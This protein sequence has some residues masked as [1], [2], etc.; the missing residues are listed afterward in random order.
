MLSLSRAQL[1]SLSI[2]VFAGISAYSLRV[3]ADSPKEKENMIVSKGKKVSIEYTVSHEGKVLSSNVG[4]QPL[5]YSQGSSEIVPGLE[6]A[7][8]GM[9]VGDTK[10]VTVSPEKGYGPVDNSAVIEV[11]K[12][13]IPP[14]AQ[15]I[16]TQLMAR[17]AQGNMLQPVVRELKDKTVMLDFNHPLAGKILQFDVKVVEV[18]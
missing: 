14:E 12:E 1:V 13:Q 15:K 5:T 7:M 17:D 16:G 18:Q 9:H 2:L 10:Q 11:P 6:E 8:E 3:E 4:K